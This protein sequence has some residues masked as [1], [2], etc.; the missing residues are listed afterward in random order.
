MDVL[1]EISK[2]EARLLRADDDEADI[3]RE[4]LARLRR[5][6]G[7][8]VASHGLDVAEQIKAWQ[9]KLADL[10]AEDREL[11]ALGAT[12]SCT[13]AVER[14]ERHVRRLESLR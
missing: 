14:V 1:Q 7:E 5:M 13:A 2:W 4:H 8:V 6:N 12:R 10:R 11:R 3:V 9:A